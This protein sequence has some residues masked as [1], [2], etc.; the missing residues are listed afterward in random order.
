MIAFSRRLARRFRAVCAKCVAG[1]PRGPGPCAV[2]RRSKDRVALTATFPEMTLELTAP[3]PGGP[4]GDEI[5]IVPMAALEAVEGNSDEPVEFE[6]GEKLVG[7]ARWTAHGTPRSVPV[8][9]VLPGKHHDPLPRPE[10]KPVA[11][12][13]LPAL[14]EAGRT[15]SRED[16][17]FALSRV[18]VRGTKGQVIAT[19]GK[20]AVLYSRFVFPFVDDVLVP[21]LPLFGCPELRD[22]TE[23]RMGRTREHLVVCA[24]DWTAWLAVAPAGKFPDVA[25]AIPRGGPTSVGLNRL[26]AADLLAR[27]PGLPGQDLEHRPVTLDADGVLT[28]R[29][30]AGPNGV[31]NLSR[32]SVAGP[33]QRVALDRRALARVLALGCHALR[34]TPGKAVVGEGTGVIVLVAPLDPAQAPDTDQPVPTLPPEPDPE[35]SEA[36]KPHETNGHAAN[37]RP[38]PPPETI[39]PLTAAE[40]LRAALGE[41]LTKAGRLVAALKVGKKERKALAHVYAGLKQLNLE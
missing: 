40:E 18:Q 11:A 34:L 26:D 6:V 7:A 15:A 17:R 32:S 25:G 41:A 12:R 21:A 22:E 24:G 2:L 16:G 8:T 10:T 27:L 28:V 19:D 33:A 23:V 4:T 37:G 9:F 36:M 13:L 3:A 30:G 14:H 31:V 39:D 20:V 38:D 5:L 35:R 1:R 29:A